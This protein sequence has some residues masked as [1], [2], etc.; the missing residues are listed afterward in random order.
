MA[1]V[2]DLAQKYLVGGE[3]PSPSQLYTEAAPSIQ[4]ALRQYDKAAPGI[5]WMLENKVLVVGTA[6]VLG[7]I[8][9]VGG[10][11]LFE[12]LKKR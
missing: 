2:L 4:V 11:Y 5:D 10:N 7:A 3:G 9:V 6:L 1:G 12:Y 8:A